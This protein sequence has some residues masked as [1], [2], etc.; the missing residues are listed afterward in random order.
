MGDIGTLVVVDIGK[1]KNDLYAVGPRNREHYFLKPE[2][3]THQRYFRNIY[4]LV[5]RGKIC[6]VKADIQWPNAILIPPSESEIAVR[7]G[8]RMKKEYRKKAYYRRTRYIN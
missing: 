7:E 3:Q 6:V 2:D 4:K 1:N 5:R 8:A